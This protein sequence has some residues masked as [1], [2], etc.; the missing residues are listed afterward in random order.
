MSYEFVNIKSWGHWTI[1][2]VVTVTYARQTTGK[3]TDHQDWCFG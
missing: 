1:R 2:T 3:A